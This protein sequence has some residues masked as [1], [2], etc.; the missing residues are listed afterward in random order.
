MRALRKV[1]GLLDSISRTCQGVS[2]AFQRRNEVS[3]AFQIDYIDFERH[4]NGILE[5]SG[6][7]R[8]ISWG[9]SRG[10]QDDFRVFDEPFKDVPRGFRFILN[11]LRGFQ[12][13]FNAIMGVSEAFQG[14]FEWFQGLFVSVQEPFEVVS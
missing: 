4:F 11:E 10:F 2:G 12:G 9:T 13:V 7:F 3:G 8:G 1:S 6:A 14:N 5:V